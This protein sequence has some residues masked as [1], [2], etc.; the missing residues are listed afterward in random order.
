MFNAYVICTELDCVSL[1]IYLFTLNMKMPGL[2][3]T[4]LLEWHCG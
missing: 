3:L 4:A 2:N 1:F